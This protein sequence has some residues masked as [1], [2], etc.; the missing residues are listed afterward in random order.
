MG[1][2]MGRGGGR[3]EAI[4]HDVVEERRKPDVTLKVAI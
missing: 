4:N 1:R 2:G 3:K